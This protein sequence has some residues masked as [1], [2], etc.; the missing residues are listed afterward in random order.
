MDANGVQVGIV[1]WGYGCGRPDYPGVYARISG[2]I[3][4]INDQICEL[5]DNPP[6]FCS[7]NSNPGND[8]PGNPNPPDNDNPPADGKT[9][10]KMTIVLDDFPGETG[11]L[12]ASARGEAVVDYPYGS[13]Q[14]PG[15]FTET[16]DL[17]PGEYQFKISDSYGDGTCCDYGQGRFE[18]QALLPDGEELLAEGD[19]RFTDSIVVEFSVPSALVQ[20]PPTT[21]PPVNDP[22]VQDPPSGVCGDKEGAFLVDSEVGNADCAWLS[23][24]L[25]RYRYLCQFLDVAAT[26]PDTCDACQYF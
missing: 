17:A 3:D 26:C 1:S 15:V 14:S 5:S 4:W 12:V 23:V 8:N 19:G 22:P 18:V 10:V 24:N 16:V 2:V 6:D 11:L 9:R 21:D 25:L 20:D 13:F 7:D